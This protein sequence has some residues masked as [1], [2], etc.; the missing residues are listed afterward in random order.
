MEQKNP[1]K[2]KILIVEDEANVGEFIKAFLDQHGYRSGIAEDGV[3][4]EKYIRSEEFCLILTDVVFFQSGGIDL[5]KAIRQKDTTTPIVVMT[6]YG[7][8]V[9][10]EAMEAGADDFILKPFDIHQLKK[11]L[12]R[13]I[14]FEGTE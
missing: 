11:K 12:G 10:Q 7:P 5:I 14:D 8:E 4:A 9:A 1:T 3:Q 13:F 2:G 6:G